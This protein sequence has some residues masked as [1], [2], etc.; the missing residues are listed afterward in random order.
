MSHDKTAT[1]ILVTP[2]GDVKKSPEMFAAAIAEKLGVCPEDVIVLTG[3]AS[4]SFAT[5]PAELIEAKAKADAAKAKAQAAAVKEAEAV[6]KAEAI[7]EK[8]AEK[9]HA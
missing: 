3:V 1:K 2:T 4:I 9:A 6:E 5:I 8:K 7:K